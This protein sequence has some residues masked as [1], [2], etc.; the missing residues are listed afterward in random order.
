MI[1]WLDETAA[2]RPYDRAAAQ[3]GLAISAL[4]T[5]SEAFRQ[6][7]LD[8]CLHPDILG[9]IREEMESAISESGWTMAALAKMQL[10]DSV[11]KESQRFKS[12]IG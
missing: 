2:G 4:H 9:P 10:L 7:L 6:V 3:L 1:T 8:L 5:T 11:M 12:A